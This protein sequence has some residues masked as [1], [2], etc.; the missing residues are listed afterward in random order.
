MGFMEMSF[1]RE[2]VRGRS[3]WTGGDQVR[4]ST[5]RKHCQLRWAC[6][7]LNRIFLFI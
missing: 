6:N 7:F 3:E 5:N 1:F 2:G 4:P